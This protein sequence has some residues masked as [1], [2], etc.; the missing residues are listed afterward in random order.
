MIRSIDAET[1]DFIKGVPGL[2]KVIGGCFSQ[3]RL[4]AVD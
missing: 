2:Q 4:G 1:A 3:K